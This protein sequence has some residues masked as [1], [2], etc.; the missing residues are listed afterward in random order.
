MIGSDT[1]IDMNGPA[2]LERLRQPK[3]RSYFGL[4]GVDIETMLG[5]YLAGPWR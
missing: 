1:P 4:S 2:I 5:P 3:V